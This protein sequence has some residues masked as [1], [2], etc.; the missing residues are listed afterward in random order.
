M[1]ANDAAN[2]GKPP[3]ADAA[4]GGKARAIDWEAIER[5]YRAGQLSVS[6]IGRQHGLSHTAINKRA[7]AQGWTRDLTERVRK[8]VSTLL[9]SEGVSSE[10]LRETVK[11]AAARVVQLVREHRADIRLNREAVKKLLDDLHLAVDH[12]A[13]IEEEIEADTEIEGTEESRASDR[14][15]LKR[16]GR[17]LA[18]VALPSNAQVANQLASALKTLVALERQ[19]FA[20][21]AGVDPDKPEGL[22]TVPAQPVELTDASLAKLA[23]LLD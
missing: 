9:V 17:M 14:E 6:E 10:G 2:D 19:A 4:K 22:P 1:T 8:E 3:A 20:L 7:K 5:E 15:K 13:E 23:R 21:E 11:E 18:A 12:R 16:R